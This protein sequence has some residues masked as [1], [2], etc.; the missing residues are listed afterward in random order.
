MTYNSPRVYNMTVFDIEP[1]YKETNNTT[2]TLSEIL[3]RFDEAPL[4]RSRIEAVDVITKQVKTELFVNNEEVKSF[5]T[6]TY[7]SMVEEE[8]E[9]LEDK[10]AKCKKLKTSQYIS[11]TPEYFDGKIAILEDQINYWKNKL[12]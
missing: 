10:L 7:T 3:K 4:L 8:V 6:Q 11:E 5:I 9:Y 2:M 1:R 12:K